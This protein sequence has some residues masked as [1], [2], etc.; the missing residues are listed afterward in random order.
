MSTAN[1]VGVQPLPKTQMVR[2]IHIPMG[3][4]HFQEILNKGPLMQGKATYQMS[5]LAP[6]VARV[7]GP[8]LAL[9]IG[10]HVGLWSMHLAQKF[11]RVEAFE[12]LP[13]HVECFRL[14]M[15][16]L[17]NVSLHTLAL[18]SLNGIAGVMPVP[19][20]SGNARVVFECK[21]GGAGGDGT[22][23]VNLHRLDDLARARNIPG[24]NFIKID[25]EGY[26]YEVIVGGEDFIKTSRPVMVVEQKP[27]NAE[28]HGTKTGAAIKLLLSWGAK[29]VWERSGDYCLEWG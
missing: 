28:R 27:G 4:L 9:D 24:A 3:D 19:D 29:V 23:V 10:A 26:E 15:A 8:H 12:P 11:K 16:G 17:K 22:V 7:K 20:N 13:L 21:D 25:V 5:K 2:G 6:A 14:N 1:Q 18:G